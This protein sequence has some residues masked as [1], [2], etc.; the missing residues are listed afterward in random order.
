[1]SV[2]IGDKVF[3]NIFPP[4]DGVVTAIQNRINNENLIGVLRMDT[5][6]IFW[7]DE[8]T[9]DVAHIDKDKIEQDD[10]IID[11][12]YQEVY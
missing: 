11:V 5:G 8:G 3:H 9:W 1:M 4:I 6:T 10:N 12:E 2:K 7:D